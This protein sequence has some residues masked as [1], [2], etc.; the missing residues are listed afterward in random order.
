VQLDIALSPALLRADEAEPDLIERAKKDPAAFAT[1][2][3]QH[4]A[5]VA[6]YILRRI[7]DAHAAEDLTAEVFLLAL[8]YLPRYRQRGLPLRVWLYRIAINVINRWI[9]RERWR[10]RIGEFFSRG[11]L[12]H[13]NLQ[14]TVPHPG[15]EGLEA[16]AARRALLTLPGRFQAALTLHYLEGMTLEEVAATV[17]CPIGTV[18]SRLS[19][20]RDM[21]RETL[22]RTAQA[23]A[24]Q[25][26]AAHANSIAQAR[27]PR[28]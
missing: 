21:L 12:G 8:R 23:E 27:R 7:G 13:R 1:L 4:Y 14:S 9:R 24:R 28:K 10:S 11:L 15:A 3:R 16:E 2:Y 17:G 5:V 22:E 18:K 25:A 20:G 26:A 6:R 19:R